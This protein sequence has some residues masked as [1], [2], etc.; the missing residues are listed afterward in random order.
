MLRKLSQVADA[1]QGVHNV[2]VHKIHVH[3]HV[4]VCVCVCVCVCVSAGV[5][6]VPARAREADRH[7]HVLRRHAAGQ[8]PSTHAT[9]M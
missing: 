7:A 8:D 9:H 1:V 2:A 5:L 3:L 4:F 6:R